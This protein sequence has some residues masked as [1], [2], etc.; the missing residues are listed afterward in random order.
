MH[1]N[2]RIDRMRWLDNVQPLA[3]I[4]D[5]TWWKHRV[6]QTKQPGKYLFRTHTFAMMSAMKV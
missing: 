3:D 5:V 4:C 1:Y 2:I 6:Q